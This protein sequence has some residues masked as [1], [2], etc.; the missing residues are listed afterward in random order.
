MIFF[1]QREGRKPQSREEMHQRLEKWTDHRGEGGTPGITH[2]VGFS[3]H[4]QFSHPELRIPDPGGGCSSPSSRGLLHIPHILYAQLRRNNQGSK[5][6]PQQGSHAPRWRHHVC[7]NSPS[8]S[9]QTRPKMKGLSEDE[10]SQRPRQGCLLCAPQRQ[11]NMKEVGKG[12]GSGK[13][14]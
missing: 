1:V 6:R 13:E 8:K 9:S 14:R 10:G 12:L 7:G 11:K 2:C 3:S 5:A 4:L